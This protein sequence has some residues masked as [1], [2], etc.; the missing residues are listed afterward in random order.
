MKKRVLLEARKAPVSRT[1]LLGKLHNSTLKQVRAQLNK[2]FKCRGKVIRL[3]ISHYTL[4]IWFL[5][6][7]IYFSSHPEDSSEWKSFKQCHSFIQNNCYLTGKTKK[8]NS[9]Q[10]A[11]EDT[12]IFRERNVMFI[13]GLWHRH[14][15]QVR[16]FHANPFANISPIALDS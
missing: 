13:S 7:E 10:L 5:R 12:N 11:I 4:A 1:V 9:C 8:D 14:K 6:L 2:I 16:R 3:T 15:I